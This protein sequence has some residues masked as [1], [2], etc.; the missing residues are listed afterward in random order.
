MEVK[1]SPNAASHLVVQLEWIGGLLQE[2]K[3]LVWMLEEMQ[4]G[5]KHPRTTEYRHTNDVSTHA[6]LHV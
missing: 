5:A 2:R 6:A 4:S 3:Y 1:S